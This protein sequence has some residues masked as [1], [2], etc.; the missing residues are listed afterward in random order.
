LTAGNHGR[1]LTGITEW[2]NGGGGAA[3]A[4]NGGGGAALG[5]ALVG[6]FTLRVSL[7]RK[8]AL[9]WQKCSPRLTSIGE[10]VLF[11]THMALLMEQIS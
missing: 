4:E 6:T 8:V 7:T 9:A 2:R 1:R 5:A 10:S 11:V 3:L